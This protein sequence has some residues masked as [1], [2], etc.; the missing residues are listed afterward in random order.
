MRSGAK[1][2]FGLVQG[3]IKVAWVAIALASPVSCGRQSERDAKAG[4]SAAPVPVG[5]AE[6]VST[7]AAETSEYVGQAEAVHSVDIRARVAGQL[8]RVVVPEGKLVKRG[9]L[10]FVV[11]PRPY[12]AALARARAT[13]ER[14]KASAALARIDQARAGELLATKSIAQQEWD[15]RNSSLDQLLGDARAAAADVSTA[16]LNL[17]FAFVRAP[18]DGRIGRA[19]ITVGNLVGPDTPTPLASLTSVDPIYV[20]FDVEEARTLR[21]T[22]PRPSA[23][24]RR[25]DGD[26]DGD[27]GD[28]SFAGHVGFAGEDG[29]PHEGKL[30]FIDNRVDS[31]TGTTRLR[32][33]VPNPDGRLSAGLFARVQLPDG[34]PRQMLLVSDRAVGT[35]QDRRFVYVV[36]RDNKV[37]YRRVQL[38][39]SVDGLRVAREGLAPGERIVVRGLQRVQPGAVVSP[40]VVPMTAIDQPDAAPPGSQ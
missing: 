31:A 21:L 2:G 4:P 38:G 17:E 29:F 33:V 30:D 22:R 36:D 16:E 7:L 9:D 18:V 32:L 5:V 12:E 28:E 25:S 14:A 40:E 10:L 39:S 11:D 19:N 26:P 34:K 35:D 6:P 37:Q 15:T 8:E 13:L 1:T 20:Y 23:A 3:R 24:R 27:A